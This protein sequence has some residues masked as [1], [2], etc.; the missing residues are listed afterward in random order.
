M[1][2]D[3]EKQALICRA[4]ITGEILAASSDYER[5][6]LYAEALENAGSAGLRAKTARE[7]AQFGITVPLSPRTAAQVWREAL[8]Q[9]MPFD[10]SPLLPP[11][12]AF[13]VLTDLDD[14]LPLPGNFV[15]AVSLT[16]LF[17]FDRRGF[18][19]VS[20]PLSGTGSGF[21]DYCG[22]ICSA[23]SRFR[24]NGC[25]TA[26][27][28]LPRLPFDLRAQEEDLTELLRR[29]AKHDGCGIRA[30]EAEKLRTALFLRL[31]RSLRE[32]GLTLR[33]HFGAAE[34][35]ARLLPLPDAGRLYELLTL[36]SER[37]VLPPVLLCP[38]SAYAREAAE[39]LCGVLPG[40]SVGGEIAWGALAFLRQ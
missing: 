15:P 34:Y 33:L 12:E 9:L 11:R 16:P 20:A 36:A 32:M 1:I 24:E 31:S 28:R 38:E 17:G 35:G 22:A 39:A 37:G 7:L 19:Q 6:C 26:V 18:A 5:L 14:P 8:P 21:A 29:A 40:F 4:G 13:A 10:P 27:L 3:P 23:L 25:D 2:P 30:E